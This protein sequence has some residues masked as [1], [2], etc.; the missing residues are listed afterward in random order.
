MSTGLPEGVRRLIAERIDS[1]EQLEVLLLLWRNPEC[2]WTPE[3]VARELRIEPGSAEKRL[4]DLERGDFLQCRDRAR[5]QFQ[6][7]PISPERDALVRAL[8]D[9]YAERRVT[10][11]NL[12]FSK[13]VD[14]I[15]TFA[16]AFRLWKD[17][18]NHG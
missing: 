1:V 9:G 15:R 12:I 11:I 13:P 10:V 16:D 14:R 18:D 8:A 4:T 2:A 6:Y 7:A 5:R 17:E 3:A